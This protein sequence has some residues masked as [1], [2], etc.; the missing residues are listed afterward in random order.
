MTRTKNPSTKSSEK[1]LHAEIKQLET[2]VNEMNP[3]QQ[4]GSP[5]IAQLAGKLARL[6]K[7]RK[8]FNNSYKSDRISREDATLRGS[9]L[10]D[11]FSAPVD[12]DWSDE[13]RDPSSVESDGCR[14]GWKYGVLSEAPERPGPRFHTPIWVRN[15]NQMYTFGQR[16]LRNYKKEHPTLANFVKSKAATQTQILFDYFIEHLEYAELYDKYRQPKNDIYDVSTKDAKTIQE[17]IEYSAE[18]NGTFSAFEEGGN[19][20]WDLGGGVTGLVT[21]S[22]FDYAEHKFKLVTARK[23]NAEIFRVELHN[24]VEDAYYLQ[25]K[26]DPSKKE[27][28]RPLQRYIEDLVCEG[29]KLMKI[30]KPD[31]NVRA[32]KRQVRQAEED[33]VIARNQLG[34]GA[35]P[36]QYEHTDTLSDQSYRPSQAAA[37]HAEYARITA[38]ENVRREAC[39]VAQR[40]IET[41]G[42]SPAEITVLDECRLEMEYADLMARLNP[43]SSWPEEFVQAKTKW[44]AAKLKSPQAK[45]RFD[46]ATLELSQPPAPIV[47]PAPVS[48]PVAQS[49][50]VAA[51]VTPTVSHELLR[52]SLVCF[53][54]G[55][56]QG[57]RSNPPWRGH[58]VPAPGGVIPA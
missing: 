53:L 11:S 38:A 25:E 24:E 34:G 44:I 17:A 23:V 6:H 49:E 45:V 35:N 8:L 27:S 48:S 12:T 13:E 40:R 31:A 29:Y 46:R 32:T 37:L 36:L 39:S 41:Q 47:K 21:M 58:R 56:V 52:L 7:N 18:K 2:A 28:T 20:P 10:Q 55:L 30:A 16:L 22:W 33:A 14:G 1:K 15:R 26:L 3:L 19:V 54:A 9:W 51:P 4:C 57:R 5:E 50:P 43:N 42:M